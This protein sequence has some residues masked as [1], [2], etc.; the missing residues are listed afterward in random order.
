[1]YEIAVLHYRGSFH[2]RYMWAPLAYLPLQ[3]VAGLVAGVADNRPTRGI[4]RALSW[5]TVAL[6][7]VGT[8]MH[9]RGVRRQMG[10]LYEWRYNGMTGPPIIAPPQVAI[11]GLV[12]ALGTSGGNTREL[13]RRLRLIEAVAQ[14]LLAGEAGYYHYA[15]YYANKLQYVPVT[16]APALAVA[17]AAAETPMAPVRRAGCSLEE[18]LSTAAT[19]SGLVGFGFHFRNVRNRTGGVSWQNLFYGAPLVA[20]LQLSGQGLLGLLAA[21]FDRRGR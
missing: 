1:W 5:G 20:P 19:L 9:L 10:G 13:V 17:Q 6:G 15:N 16:L 2:S 12:G 7:A 3:M 8:L 18:V 21:Y 4:F 11:F 14:L